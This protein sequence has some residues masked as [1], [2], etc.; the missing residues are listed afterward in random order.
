MPNIRLIKRRIKS[1]KN[2]AQITRAMEM[3]AAS[4]MRRAQQQAVS[5]KAYAMKIYEMV[6]RLAPRVDATNHPLLGKPASISGKR[7]IITIST[8]KGLCGGLNTNL[9]RFMG[10]EY[11][12]PGRQNHIIIGKKATSFLSRITTPESILADFSAEVP[13]VR[14]V[15]A[16][17]SLITKGFIGGECDGVDIVYNEFVSALRQNPRKKTILPL[18]LEGVAR[19]EDRE[20]DGHEAHDILIEPD[21]ETVFAALLPHY[22]ENQIRDAILQAEASEHS[23]RMIAMRSATDNAQS[24]MDDL[25]LVY[26]KARQEKIT[27]EITD[28]VTARLS[29]QI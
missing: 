29:V 12:D 19:E 8:N 11:S 2:I 21:P 4:R 24:L 28:M 25:T 6:L 22:L 5:G 16:I 1:A 20:E 18:T 23:A 27:Y 14:T 13:F 10:R 9:F 26:N 7:L 17:T 15:P 3:V